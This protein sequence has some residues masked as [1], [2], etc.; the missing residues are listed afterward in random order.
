MDAVLM[1]VGSTDLGAPLSNAAMYRMVDEDWLD[2]IED[3]GVDD[4]DRF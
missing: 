1:E 4:S 2:Y 3:Y